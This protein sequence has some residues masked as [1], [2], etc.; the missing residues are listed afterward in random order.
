MLVSSFISTFNPRSSNAFI[1]SSFS[2]PV[3]FGTFTNSVPLLIFN[4]TVLFSFILEFS[5]NSGSCE[6]TFPSSTSAENSSSN[7]NF[8]FILSASHSYKVR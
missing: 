4:F 5:L 1:A 7:S 3:T 6:I 8:T 2:I